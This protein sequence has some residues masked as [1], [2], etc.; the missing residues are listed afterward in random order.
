MAKTG[1]KREFNPDRAEMEALFQSMTMLELAKHYGVGETVVWKRAK[2]FDLKREDGR[3]KRY[4]PRTD[5]HRKALSLSRRG[6]WGGEKAPN[7]RGGIHAVNMRLRSSGAYKQWKIESKKRA[8]NRC[9]G[10]GVENGSICEC[11]GTKITLHCHHLKSFAK[12]PELRFDPEN[13]EVLCP[14]CHYSRHNGKSGELLE[15]PTGK[16]SSQAP[17]V[18]ER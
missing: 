7:W 2:E 14:K 18:A 13:S 9:E 12:H 17:H 8:G 1:P 10:C 4:K 3:R 16:I 11:C 15:R 5:A 6:K